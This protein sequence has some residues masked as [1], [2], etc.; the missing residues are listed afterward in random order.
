MDERIA[1]KLRALLS[2]LR[3]PV[4]LT[5][6]QGRDQLNDGA[7]AAWVP[8]ALPAGEALSEAGQVFLRSEVMEGLVWI[9]DGDEESGA[10]ALRLADAVLAE[11]LERYPEAGGPERLY[12]QLL[13]DDESVSAMDEALTKA[14]IRRRLPRCVLV[15]KAAVP[16]HGDF[17][18]TMRTILPAGPSDVLVPVDPHT[19]AYLV[20]MSV[21]DDRA[22]LLEYANATRESVLSE[23]GCD[24]MIGIGGC[25]SDLVGLHTSY[26]QAGKSLEIGRVFQPQKTVFDYQ[27]MI[28]PRFLAALPQE[29]AAEYH[30]MLF[31][32]ETAKLFTDELLET[33]AM[34]FEKDLNLSDTARQLYIHRNTL[35]YRLD[36]IA[37]ITG[38]DLR[39]FDDAVTFRMLMEMGKC[40]KKDTV[41]TDI[42]Q[43]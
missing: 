26:A 19:V 15:I 9:A 24:V 2:G 31:N 11:L 10:D 41:I 7:P 37:K 16:W 35:T 3:R 20:D 33:V 40:G 43:M 34:F 39:H 30:D 38:L 27:Q 12:R 17:L 21:V 8:E 1:G 22:D 5:D 13:L 6:G 32:A 4:T 25:A 36:K 14:N 18:K 42:E 28:L 23:S 29:L